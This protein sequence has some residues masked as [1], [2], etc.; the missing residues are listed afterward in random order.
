MCVCVCVCVCGRYEHAH[1][2]SGKANVHTGSSWILCCKEIRFCC[3]NWD[4]GTAAAAY[5]HS[6]AVITQNN[7]AMRLL[8]RCHSSGNDSACLQQQAHTWE[9][10]EIL[11]SCSEVNV[12]CC[13]LLTVLRC[14]SGVLR[15]GNV[16]ELARL[17]A[18]PTHLQ[19]THFWQHSST[20]WPGSRLFMPEHRELKDALKS[21]H[22][23]PASIVSCTAVNWTAIG[24]Y[25]DDL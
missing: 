22:T 3:N 20:R 17:A 24:T 14:P 6:Q 4:W 9:A 25:Q 13:K 23:L 1:A 18:P 15:E 11:E 21:Y 5:P 10:A 2:L 19:C 12:F 8:A 7:M 16:M